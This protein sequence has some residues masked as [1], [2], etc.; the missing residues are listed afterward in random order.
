MSAWTAGD[1]KRLWHSLVK[2]VSVQYTDA[3]QQLDMKL[4]YINNTDFEVRRDR[5]IAASCGC[6]CWGGG[7]C[8]WGRVSLVKPVSVKYTGA[9]Q[10]LDMKL[11]YF[12]NM[13]FEVRGWGWWGARCTRGGGDPHVCSGKGACLVKLVSGKV[14]LGLTGSWA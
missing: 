12:N 3:E 6:V 10:Q 14:Q 11:P 4:T 8:T 13:D 7:T 9:E 5:G 2:P 1:S